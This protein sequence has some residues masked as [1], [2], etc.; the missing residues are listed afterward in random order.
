M[1]TD[2]AAIALALFA[3]WIGGRPASVERTFGYQRTEVLAAML[4]AL[5]LWLI[6][7]WVLFEAFQRLRE[8]PGIEGG[9]MLIVG[10]IG[11]LVNIGAALVLYRSAEHSLN[12]EGAFRHVMADL[13]GSVGVVVSGV[14]V[15]T[16]GW[17]IVDPIL[18]AGIGLLILFSSWR[19]VGKVFRVL[20]EGTLEHIDLYR[21]C[22]E[23]EDV[24]GA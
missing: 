9:L 10:A 14:L 20:L 2:A 21:L 5:S 23:F 24:E 4:N 8:P 15:L 22:S 17:T 11:L 12:V 16:L 18:G 19:L 13:L 6:A 1:L 7:G 3:I